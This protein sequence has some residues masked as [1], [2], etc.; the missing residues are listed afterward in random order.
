MAKILARNFSIS[1]GDLQLYLQALRHKSAARNIY[2]KPEMSNERLEFLGDAILD[3]IV[4][5]Y[6]FDKYPEAEEGDLTKMKSRIVS[7]N[8]LNRI[9]LEMGIADLIETDTQ[10]AQAKESIAGNALEAFFGAIYIDLGYKKTRQSIIRLFESY[11]DLDAIEFEEADFKSR[12][13]EEA[14]RRKVSL[15]FATRTSGSNGSDN[16]FVS[17]A[18]LANS[19][20]GK[21]TGTSKKR[22]EQNAAKVALENLNAQE[23]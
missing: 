15:S 8:N 4:A 19:A 2:D 10:A 22:A 12:L 11:A 5:N 23:A 6:L 21:G 16:M 14:H 20:M 9:A 13:Y 1:F 18:F 7:R 3:A 17:E